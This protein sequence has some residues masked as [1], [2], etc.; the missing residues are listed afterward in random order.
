M[1]SIKNYI[2]KQQFNPGILGIFINPFY[3]VRSKLY[4]TLSKL[5]ND[6]SGHTL[7]IGCGE[8]PYKRIFKNI[9][10]YTGMEFDS[11]KNRARF[12]N[13]DK[14]YDGQTFPFENNNFDSIIITQVLE[15]I[16]NPDQFLNEVN[17]VTKKGGF[18]LLS[19]PFVWDEHEQPYDYARYSSFGLTHLLKTHGFEMKKHLKTSPDIGV[20]FQLVACYIHKKISWIKSYKIRIIFYIFL[21]SPFTIFGIIFSKLLPKNQDLYMD[22]IVLAQKI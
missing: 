5:S 1:N 12:K 21:I 6:I 11:P 14:W 18:L 17:R 19:V 3:L 22:N 8:S 9:S 7:D 4:T 20:I 10:S 13:I 15:H 16:F 2:H